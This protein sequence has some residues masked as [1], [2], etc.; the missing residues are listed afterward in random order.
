MLASFWQH[1]QNSKMWP[2]LIKEVLNN[3]NNKLTFTYGRS[4]F[5]L[6]LSMLFTLRFDMSEKQSYWNYM[7]HEM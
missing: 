1:I 3:N 4:Y 7:G 6:I 2:T 5:V